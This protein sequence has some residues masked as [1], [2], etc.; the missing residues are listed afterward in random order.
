MAK[1]K[2]L[3]KHHVALLLANWGDRIEPIFFEKY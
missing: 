1:K 2:R 3:K